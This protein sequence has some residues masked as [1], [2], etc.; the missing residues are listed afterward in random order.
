M[1][2]HVSAYKQA[3]FTCVRVY[4]TYFTRACR[5]L[6]IYANGVFMC[7]YMFTCMHAELVCVCECVYMFVNG[8]YMFVHGV[9][10]CVCLPQDPP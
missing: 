2:V 9:Y 1:Y 3:E 6:Y 7:M 8:V 10:M 5:C 4:T